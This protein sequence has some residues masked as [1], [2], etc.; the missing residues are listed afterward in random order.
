MERWRR[1]EGRGEEVKGGWGEV[2]GG[3]K[4]GGRMEGRGKVVDEVSLE[5]GR[6]KV[7]DSQR[8]GCI[9]KVGEEGGGW[10]RGVK[11]SY[12]QVSQAPRSLPTSTKEREC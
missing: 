2:E 11:L 6:G 10:R 4:G 8:E 12:P 9:L 1:M 7:V 5:G 3:W